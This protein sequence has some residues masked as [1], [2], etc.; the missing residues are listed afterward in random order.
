M[1]RGLQRSLVTILFLS[2]LRA[3]DGFQTTTPSRR[4]PN[5]PIPKVL[6]PITTTKN[7]NH[8]HYH[9]HQA[10]K[11]GCKRQRRSTSSELMLVPDPSILQH[12]TSGTAEF[13]MAKA[14][15]D[16]SLPFQDMANNLSRSMRIAIPNARSSVP[17][18]ATEI[19]LGSMGMDLLIFLASSVLVTTAAN[20]IKITPI[21]GYLILGALLGPN[22]LDIFSNAQADV[23]LGDFGILFLLFSEGLEVTS[24]RLRKLANYLPLGMA[25]ISLTTGII[26]A[27]LLALGKYAPSTSAFLNIRDPIQACI[28]AVTCTLS[29]SAFI[30][31]VL[32]EREW[33]E[34]QSGAS[35]TTILLLQDLL[36]APLL[37]LL[38]YLVG[39]GPTDYAAIGFLTLKATVG[40]GGVIF[41]GSLILQQIFGM[42]SQTRS[43]ETFVALCLLVSA[44]MGEIAKTLGLTDTAGAFAAGV[45]LANT[46]YRAQIQADI[47][48][49]KGILLGIFFMDA[50]SNFDLNL[51][52][53]EWQYV[54]GGSAA[55]VA[56]K[57]LTLFGATNVP[58]RFER[59]RLPTVDGIRI[60]ILLAG[61]GEFAFVVLALAGK[62]GV[63][64]DDLIAILTA[65]VLVTMGIT[66]IL[67]DVAALVSQPFEIDETDIDEVNAKDDIQDIAAQIEVAE[68]SIVVCGHAEIGR[69]VLRKLVEFRDS[70]RDESFSNSERGIPDIVAFSRNPSLVDSVLTP[71]PGAIVLYGDGNNPTVIKSSGVTNPKGIFVTYNDGNVVLAA[72]ARLR[73]AFPDTPIYARASKRRDS[74]NLRLAGATTAVVE[75]DE[76]ARAIPDIMRGAWEGSLDAGDYDAYDELRQ[77]AASAAQIPLTVADELIELYNS[78]DLCATGLIGRDEVV[79]MFRRTKRG[80][81]ASDSEIAEMEKW[82]KSSS[83]HVMD[84]LD[85]VEFCR[86][87]AR[88]PDFVKKSF[89]VIKQDQKPPRK[90]SRKQ[91]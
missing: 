28:L 53:Q 1:G 20:A 62:I 14:Q 37:V 32:K 77:S 3:S 33:E 84:P 82:L 17:E 4:I 10:L 58:K 78:L 22:G 74:R 56:I 11:H 52:L 76:L 55:L 16:F 26:T 90:Q 61:G 72:T 46:N 88:A 8:H 85:R 18:E 42:V 49:F 21:L 63:L 34:E 24:V 13:L 15:L 65:I 87:Y 91:S 73:A 81:V 19:V 5:V 67:G 43:S 35:A 38:P 60:A 7:H 47:L 30:F 23:G 6:P 86:L 57:A 51:V 45:L 89:G 64:S 66:P 40:F 70:S 48:P 27:A 71:A 2:K 83:V 75:G 41:L 12:S 36:V 29:T 54:F 44:G 9:H 50:G 31:P 79:E 80:F 25:Q 59:N 39:S 68:D 69:A